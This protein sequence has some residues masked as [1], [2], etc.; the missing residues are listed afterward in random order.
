MYDA[1]DEPLRQLG[2]EFRQGGIGLGDMD[3]HEELGSAGD[4]QP[5]PSG[6]TRLPRIGA[7]TSNPVGCDGVRRNSVGTLTPVEASA[8]LIVDL[9]AGQTNDRFR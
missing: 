2:H 7:V 8:C 6:S 5:A 3:E 4:A 9:V 1:L